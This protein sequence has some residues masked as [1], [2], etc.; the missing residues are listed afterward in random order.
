VKSPEAAKVFS[1]RVVKRSLPITTGDVSGNHLGTE[2][3]F[4]VPLG[5]SFGNHRSY[6]EDDYAFEVVKT[7]GDYDALIP[8]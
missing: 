7:S 1:I 4:T 3:L 2:N 5:I 8:A 6:N